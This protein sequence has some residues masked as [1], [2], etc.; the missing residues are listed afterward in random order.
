MFIASKPRLV[1][2][3]THSPTSL[4]KNCN[5]KKTAGHLPQQTSDFNTF[6]IT[7]HFFCLT[8]SFFFLLFRNVLPTKKY[9]EKLKVRRLFLFSFFSTWAQF[10]QRVT[11]SF[12]TRRSRAFTRADPESVKRLSIFIHF[13]DLRV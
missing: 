6:L 3:F 5:C 12:Y 10:H 4:L 8:I 9:N 1:K 7:F 13:W 2:L 11:Y